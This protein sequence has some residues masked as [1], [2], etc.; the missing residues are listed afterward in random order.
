MQLYNAIQNNNTTNHVL[1]PLRFVNSIMKV[2]FTTD[3][4]YLV[5]YKVLII[6]MMNKKLI[7]KDKSQNTL[8]NSLKI[9]G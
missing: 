6:S 5:I 2:L 8:C 9:L 4:L 3:L 7:A 1:N